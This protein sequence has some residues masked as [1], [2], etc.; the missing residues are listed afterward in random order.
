MKTPKGITIEIMFTARMNARDNMAR[1]K[2]QQERMPFDHDNNDALERY[3]IRLRQ[4]EGAINW[5][6]KL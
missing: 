1:A 3:Q 6:E 4:I 5:L 2:M